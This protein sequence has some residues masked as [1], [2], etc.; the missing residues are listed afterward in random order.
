MPTNEKLTEDIAELAKELNLKISTE[1]MGSKE[2]TN[3]LADL[4][5]KKKDAE[6]HTEADKAEKVRRAEETAAKKKASGK[7]NLVVC[8]GKSVC[9][10]KRGIL[11]PGQLIRPEWFP[12]G[13][14]DIA[15]LIKRGVV[16]KA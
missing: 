12:G 1:G 16:D 10:T 4:R 5:A 14:N 9:C 8:A 6:R 15:K 13:K 3:E 7:A 2:L 11:G